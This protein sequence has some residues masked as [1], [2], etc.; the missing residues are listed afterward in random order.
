[1]KTL[2]KEQANMLVFNTNGIK[3]KC[4]KTK[5]TFS[6]LRKK[7]YKTVS[8]IA[9]TEVPS[10]FLFSEKEGR[11]FLCTMAGCTEVINASVKRKGWIIF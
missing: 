3:T 10:H 5:E 1:M 9:Q 2:T 11:L 4:K 8:E 6:S 7:G